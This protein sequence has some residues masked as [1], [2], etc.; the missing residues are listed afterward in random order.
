[1]NNPIPLRQ[2]EDIPLTP[3]NSLVADVRFALAF[4]NTADRI[5]GGPART[6]DSAGVHLHEVTIQEGH[7]TPTGRR[8]YVADPSRTIR[9][10]RRR[11]A[12]AQDFPVRW[13][14]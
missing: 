10:E 8:I 12:L 2:G 13:A 6:R 3:R 7:R 11:S 4:H 1:M 9:P 5:A 14:K